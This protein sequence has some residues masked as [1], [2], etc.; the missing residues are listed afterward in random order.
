[1]DLLWGSRGSVIGQGLIRWLEECNAL[2]LPA[3]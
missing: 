3:H 1:V 2:L